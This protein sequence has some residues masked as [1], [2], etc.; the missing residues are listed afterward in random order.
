MQMDAT[1]NTRAM[2]HAETA[3]LTG[4]L[5]VSL[6]RQTR[7][8]DPARKECDTPWAGSSHIKGALC[9]VTQQ[10]NN[11]PQGYCK[12][13]SSAL[14][15]RIDNFKNEFLASLNHFDNSIDL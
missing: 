15:S 2:N 11:V 4:S 9:P 1:E 12:L 6:D 13:R 10:F 14:S 3:S 8:K 7:A 5:Q